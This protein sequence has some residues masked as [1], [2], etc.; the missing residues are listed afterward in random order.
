MTS[1]L[2]SILNTQ[3]AWAALNHVDVDRGCTRTLEDNLFCCPMHADTLEEFRAGS[4]DETGRTTTGKKRAKMLSLRS[5][6]VLAVNVF[7]HWRGRDLTQLADAL[8][9]P[10]KYG[11][12]KFEQPFNHGLSSG[13]PHLDVVLYSSDGRRPLAI[14][15]KF[16]E[17]YDV[18]KDERSPPIH[19]KYFA[20]GR[21]RWAEVELPCCQELAEH[22]GTR[23]FY[24]RLGAAQLLKHLLGLAHDD[25][26]HATPDRSVS[27]LYLWFDTGCAEAKEHQ[28]EIEDFGTRIDSGVDFRSMTYQNLFEQ[29]AVDAPTAR[30]YVDYL[31]TRYFAR[32]TK[33]P[34][35]MH[36]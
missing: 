29:L 7:D 19:A 5:S 10:G 20:S 17:P 21:K 27:L 22:L 24:H 34:A 36:I 2:T 35:S 12:L 32:L 23:T 33:L 15:A 8:E 25:D 31:R 11:N 13:K 1:A 26:G 30:D 9:S 6:S 18:K 16:A 28:D 3:H 14:E 4:G